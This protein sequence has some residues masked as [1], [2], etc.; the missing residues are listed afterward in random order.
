MCWSDTCNALT[1]L[2]EWEFFLETGHEN[3]CLCVYMLVCVWR[4]KG[5][6]KGKGPYT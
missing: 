4:S 2:V 3:R 1:L 6:G 5:I